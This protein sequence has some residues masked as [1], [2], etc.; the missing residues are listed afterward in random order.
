MQA[1]AGF[2]TLLAAIRGGACSRAQLDDLQRLCGRELDVSDGILPTRVSTCR[3]DTMTKARHKCCLHALRWLP[4]RLSST[5]T[6]QLQFHTA[7]CEVCHRACRCAVDCEGRYARSRTCETYHV[8]NWFPTLLHV[9]RLV[10]GPRCARSCSRTGRTWTPSTRPSWRRC[11]ATPCALR[12]RTT[13]GRPTPCR[14]RA[15]CAGYACIWDPNPCPF[16][17]LLPGAVK[18]SGQCRLPR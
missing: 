9:F 5:H 13:A 17:G 7:L 15:R 14:Q 18:S 11:R 6:P 8:L 12:H 3:R 10:I 16:M 1:D 2:V 4:S